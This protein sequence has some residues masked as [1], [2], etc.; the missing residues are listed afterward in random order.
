MLGV[1]E[2]CCITQQI[3]IGQRLIVKGFFFEISI[4]TAWEILVYINDEREKNV[5]WSKF[6]SFWCK[7]VCVYVRALFVR[8]S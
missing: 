3:S 5:I 4:F 2:I 7:C 1:I 6:S 8:M